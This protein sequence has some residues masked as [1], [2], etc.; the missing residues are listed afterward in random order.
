MSDFTL[1]VGKDSVTINLNESLP[2]TD[3]VEMLRFDDADVENLLRTHSGNQSYWEAL[4][5]RLRVRFEKYKDEWVKKWWAYHRLYAKNVLAAYGDSKPTMDALQDMTILVYS[6]ETSDEERKKY[7]SLA[8]KVAQSKAFH[9]SEEEYAGLMYRYLQ[10]EVPWFFE[11]LMYNLKRL[12]EEAE[13]VQVV[14]DRMHAQAFHL[15]MYAK[16]QIAR[17]GNVDGSIISEKQRLED[18]QGQRKVR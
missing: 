5:I 18:L 12:Q 15:D 1:Q 3:V 4:A 7:A 2:M 11:T 6:S 10:M 16:M 8:Y 9:G 17:K 13:T 14:A